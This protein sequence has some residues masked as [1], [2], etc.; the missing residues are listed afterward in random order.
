M[1]NGLLQP[2]SARAAV[3]LR[4][5]AQTGTVHFVGIAGAGVSAI[6]ELVLR[7]GGRVSGCDTNPGAVGAALAALGARVMRGHDPSHVEDAVAV[8][9]TAAVPSTHPELE[10]ARQRGLPVLKRAEALGSIVNRGH[11]IAV[12][13]THG[14][15]TTTAMTSA[16]LAEAGL[17]PTAFVGGHVT[18]WG[19]GLRTGSDALFVVEADEYDRSFLTLVPAAAAITSIEADHLD[20]YGTPAAVHE[21]FRAFADL[22]PEDGLLTACIDDAGARHVLERYPHSLG[23][24]TSEAAVLR[25]VDLVVEGRATNCIV[26]EHSTSLGT[27]R[28]NV[29]G[30]HNVRN[31]LAAFALARNAGADFSAAQNALGRFGGVARRMQELGTVG[32]ITIVDDY[33]HHPT[34]IAATLA[35]VRSAYPG[36]RIVAAFQPHLFTRTRDFTVEFGVALAA[37]D[38]VLVADVYAAR[39]MPIE[40][41]SGALIARAAERAGARRVRYIPHLEDVVHALVHKLQPGDLCVTMGAGNIDDAARLLLARLREEAM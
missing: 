6:A 12:A 17:D 7:A 9:T 24:G 20:I 2:E 27:L 38:L 1:T 40:G 32:R 29:P 18:G 21:A 4:T 16:I 19:S 13:G 11:L 31:A 23:Y 14:K 5:L 28:V 33:A 10:F 25:A 22:I 26:R 39:E 3:D 35:A 30:I 34:E 8:V 15:T 41:V 37:A 36:R